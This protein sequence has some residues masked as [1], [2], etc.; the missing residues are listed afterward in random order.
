MKSGRR[1][2]QNTI[3]RSF[4]KLTFFVYFWIKHFGTYKLWWALMSPY[5]HFF[6]PMS[7]HEH[8]WAAKSCH[9]HS[10][11]WCYDTVSTQVHSW[12]LKSDHL[13]TWALMIMMPRR[14]EHSRG[15][16]VLR[17][18]THWFSDVIRGV[19]ECSWVLIIVH[20]FSWALM[21]VHELVFM[22]LLTLMRAH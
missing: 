17:H 12:E 20:E 21:S 22:A 7:T 10:L 1:Y 9:E 18:H 8:S 6:A 3:G 4:W 11:A 5:V 15:L 2:L 13:C 16:M 19:C 14:T